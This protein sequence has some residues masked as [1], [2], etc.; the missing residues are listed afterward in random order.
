MSK[1]VINK[2]FEAE[3]DGY[4]WALSSWYEGKDKDG[5]PKRQMNKTWH[6]SFKQIAQKVIDSSIGDC[7]D[8]KEIVE[9]IDKAIL[10]IDQIIKKVEPN[11][12]TN[13]N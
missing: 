10:G 12:R 3:W 7:T 1:I 4:S 2:D 5:K 11:E 9:R 8:L 13:D 6:Y